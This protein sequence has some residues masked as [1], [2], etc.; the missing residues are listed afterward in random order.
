[1]NEGQRFTFKKDERVTGVKRIEHLFAHG[2]SFISYPLRVVFV[3]QTMQDDSSR[4]V[5]VFV[6]VPKKK[7]KSAVD[8]NRMKRLIRET[9]RL[10]KHSFDTA[11]TVSSDHNRTA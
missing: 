3:E 7:L 8:R 11:S 1:M 10:N 5:S 2:R 9:Y 6:S 4:R